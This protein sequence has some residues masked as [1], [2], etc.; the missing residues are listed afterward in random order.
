MQSPSS[1]SSIP[2]QPSLAV[3][4]TLNAGIRVSAW[5][6]VVGGG[7]IWVGGLVAVVSLGLLDSKASGPSEGIAISFAL[8]ILVGALLSGIGVWNLH[9]FPLIQIRETGLKIRDKL[10]PFAAITDVVKKE[11]MFVSVRYVEHGVTN[12]LFFGVSW[13]MGSDLAPVAQWLA[14]RAK[15]ARAE[16][17]AAAP[18]A[19]TS[20]A[21]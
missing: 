1:E 3:G 5:S 10:V 11:R 16:T 8:N 9:R 13:M 14:S 19:D 20:R 12:E 7:L 18:L 6:S 17:Q 4:E 2:D 21:G 15:A